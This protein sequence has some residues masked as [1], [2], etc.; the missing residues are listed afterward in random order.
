MKH[1]RGIDL[2]PGEEKQPLA[3]PGDATDLS[4][5]TFETLRE[6]YALSARCDR[7]HRHQQIDRSMLEKRFGKTASIHSLSSYLRCTACSNRKRNR[8]TVLKIER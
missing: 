3:A 1:R 7:C 8:F 5:L 2:G 6:W 4:G